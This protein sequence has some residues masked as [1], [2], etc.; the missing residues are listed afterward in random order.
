MVVGGVIGNALKGDQEEYLEAGVDA[1][2][3]EPVTEA[4]LKRC[5]FPADERRKQAAAERQ[6]RTSDTLSVSVLGPSSLGPS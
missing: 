6:R 3:T 5:L 1:L 2:L 4:A